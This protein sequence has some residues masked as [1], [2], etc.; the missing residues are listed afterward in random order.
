[1]AGAQVTI[2]GTPVPIF[3]A[4]PGQL[5]VQIPTEVTGTSATVQ[6]TVN[7]Q[8]SPAQAFSIDAFAPGIFT[9]NQQGNGPG[10]ITH[11]DGTTVTSG[12]PARPG[13]VV[14]IYANGLGQVTPALA[15]GTRPTGLVTALTTPTVMIDGIQAQV[16]FAGISGCCV[17]LNQINVVVPSNVHLGTDN[18]TL[19]IGAKQ[20]NTA[21]IFVA[22]VGSPLITSAASASGTAGYYFWYQITATNS[23]SS[24]GATG[25]PAGLSVHSGIG[26][27]SG[28]PAS[29]G[30]YTVILSA[31]NSVGTSTATLTLTININ[32]APSPPCIGL[33]GLWQ[34]LWRSAHGASGNFTLS[35]PAS[36]S[37]SSFGGT[38]PLVGNC[39]QSASSAYFSGTFYVTTVFLDVQFSGNTTAHLSFSGTV[40]SAGN[41]MVGTYVSNMAGPAF[42]ELCGGDSGSWSAAK[43]R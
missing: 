30:S 29:A 23:P 16:Q 37:T 6:V 8:S 7:G 13:E 12:S 10:A 19:S 41:S 18:V 25:L 40:N 11:S 22:A 43:I 2:N 36:Y 3:Y 9:T 28:T 4:T 26:L 15:T 33:C 17:G 27:I 34:F 39:G 14:V 1:M 20:S 24:F 32:P 35:I 31:S 42:P 21:T 5:G 38:F